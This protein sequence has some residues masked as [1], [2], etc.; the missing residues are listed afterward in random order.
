MKKCKFFLQLQQTIRRN[1]QHAYKL[2]YLELNQ[3]QNNSSLITRTSI[4]RSCNWRLSINTIFS[5][6]F[7]QVI[8][9]NLEILL[10]P[11]TI[12]IPWLL[13]KNGCLNVIK[14]WLAQGWWPHPLLPSPIYITSHLVT[15]DRQPPRPQRARAELDTAPSRVRVTTHTR[16]MCWAQSLDQWNSY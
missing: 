9:M 3:F 8:I 10:S 7:F 5:T 15:P 12:Y 4:H 14:K 6:I 13:S 1:N 16:H 2:C 11:D